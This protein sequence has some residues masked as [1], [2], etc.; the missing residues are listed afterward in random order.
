MNKDKISL[1]NSMDW[2]K[3][4]IDRCKYELRRYT[5]L[6][7]AN[8]HLVDSLLLKVDGKTAWIFHGD[9]G[10]RGC[11]ESYRQTAR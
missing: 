6:S 11:S 7:F 3:P 8:I 9:T 1:E 4:L 2:K 5:E 10:A